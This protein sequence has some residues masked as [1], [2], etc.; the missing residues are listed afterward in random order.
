ME[1]R[2]AKAAQEGIPLVLANLQIMAEDSKAKAA[3]VIIGADINP[4]DITGI[5][6]R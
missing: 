6:N 1:E 2:E 4:I 3:A 5:T